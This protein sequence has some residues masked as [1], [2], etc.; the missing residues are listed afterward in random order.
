[1]QIFYEYLRSNVATCSM[2]S[3]NTGIRQKCCTRYKRILEKNGYLY[4]A[5]EGKCKYTGFKAMFL[6]TNRLLM[7]KL[8]QQLELFPL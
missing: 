8:P 5:Y 3:E 4:E 2:V 1:M 7:P 6:T